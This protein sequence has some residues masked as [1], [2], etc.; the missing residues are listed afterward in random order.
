MRVCVCVMNSRPALTSHRSVVT[1]GLFFS[2][3]F[4]LS[5]FH[6]SGCRGRRQRFKQ[7]SFSLLKPDHS[8]SL[9]VR[10]RICAGLFT[11]AS[12]TLQHSNTFLSTSDLL[13]HPRIESGYSL[14]MTVYTNIVPN[15]LCPTEEIKY[16]RC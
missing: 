7:C 16:H 12:A 5:L 8:W 4:F 10:K 14:G 15:L 2:F 3:S 6:L 13:S 9:R 1:L 11:P